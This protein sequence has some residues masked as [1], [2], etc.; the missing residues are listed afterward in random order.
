M[1]NEKDKSN[2]IGTIVIVLVIIA[3]VF[4]GTYAW[5]SYRSQKTAMVLT[6]GNVNN[7]Q[8]TLTPYQFNSTISPVSSYANQKYTSVSAVNNGQSTG[9]VRLYYHINSIADELKIAS[10]KYTMER[11]TNNGS[12][13]ALYASGSGNFTTATNNGDLTIL[14]DAIPAN[15]KYK[16]KVYIW[17]D[18]NGGNQTGASGKTLDCELRAAIE[19]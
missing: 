12:S 13:Y 7:I 19:E 4:A 8:V 18:S 5:I 3:V 6:I 11:S 14:T 10:F 9:N 17:L 2:I 16:Y 1:N 15:G